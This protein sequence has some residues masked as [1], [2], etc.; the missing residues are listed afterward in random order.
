MN[1]AESIG[2]GFNIMQNVRG[3]KQRSTFASILA[4]NI[5]NILSPDRV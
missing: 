5:D 1:E 2:N 4:K 3:K